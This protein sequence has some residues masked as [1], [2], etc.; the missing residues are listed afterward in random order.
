MRGGPPPGY[1]VDGRE[2][3]LAPR[4]TRAIPPPVQTRWHNHH[5]E[6]SLDATVRPPG[7]NPVDLTGKGVLAPEANGHMRPC[8]QVFSKRP[9]GFR[10]LVSW[11]R[12]CKRYRRL[13]RPESGTRSPR[14]EVKG[15]GPQDKALFGP[16]ATPFRRNT[17]RSHAAPDASRQH[18]PNPKFGA[19]LPHVHGLFTIS[20]RRASG[21]DY[22]VIQPCKRADDVLDN[23]VPESTCVALATLKE[24][25]ERQHSD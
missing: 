20:Q 4:A 3:I 13:Y 5:R 1:P 9:V 7:R 10:P 22:N 17:Q 2:T 12:S 23:A 16:P 14:P 25:A 8:C 6:Q 19:N 18:I 11:E 24:D 21:N 15:L